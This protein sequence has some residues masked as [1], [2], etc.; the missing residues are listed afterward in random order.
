MVFATPTLELLSYVEQYVD[1]F[2]FRLSKNAKTVLRNI[3]KQIHA[4]DKRPLLTTY[5]P[6]TDNIVPTENWLYKEIPSPIRDQIEMP[7]KKGRTYT[8][9]IYGRAGTPKRYITV[10]M[11][12]P[13]PSNTNSEYSRIYDSEEHANTFF[14]S[15]IHRIAVWLQVA[16]MF[17]GKACAKQLTCYLFLTDHHKI[18]PKKDET[19]SSEFH[20]TNMLPIDTIHA[21]T[22]F[23]TACSLNSDIMLYRMEEWFK[24]FIHET[25][26]SLGLDFSQMDNTESNRQ[27][28]DLFPGCS[29]EMDVRIYETYCEMW[30]EILNVMFI[31]YFSEISR[32]CTKTRTRKDTGNMNN[33]TRRL[34]CVQS[35]EYSRILSKTIAQTEKYLEYERAFTMYQA[36]KVLQHYNR[37]YPEICSHTHTPNTYSELTPVFSYYIVKSVLFYHVNYFVEWCSRHNEDTLYFTK[38]KHN[39][40]EYG[41]LIGRLYKSNE[42]IQKFDAIMKRTQT[43]EKPNQWISQTLRMSLYETIY[44]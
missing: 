9:A 37:T 25:F 38:T 5:K 1:M 7:G 16:Y 11:I 20:S 43:L 21:N 12:L 17:A 8:F 14:E 33:A 32:V 6:I 18:L 40:R 13:K 36:S 2:P 30:A 23:T 42:F 22:A 15:S 24:V 44:M 28:L 26:H 35:V 34:G 41:R 29:R 27:I 39:I 10:H 19:I 4:S 31:A 3:C